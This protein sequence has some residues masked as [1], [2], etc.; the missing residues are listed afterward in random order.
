MR[1]SVDYFIKVKKRDVV[2]YAPYLEAFQGMLALRTPE[3]PKDGIATIH[4]FVS[5][6]YT[7]DFEKLMK[8][9]KVKWTNDREL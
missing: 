1:D 5:P 9:L 8:K 7:K 2:F 3:P 6:D 4:V